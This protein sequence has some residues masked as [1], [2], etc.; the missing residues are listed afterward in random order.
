MQLTPVTSVESVTD[1]VMDFLSRLKK[2]GEAHILGVARG[3]DLSFS[4]M[5][6]L[7]VLYDCHDELA[8]HE[9]ATRLGLS[10]ATAGR[11]VQGLVRTDMVTRRED[12]HDRRVKRVRLSEH[13]RGFVNGLL[14]AHRDAVRECLESLSD[15]ERDRLSQALLPILARGD[16]PPATTTGC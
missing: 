13:G 5:R 6:A 12:T 7:F 8:V 3:L 1:Q 14:Q 9:L 16:M 10:M 15:D 11:A 4:Q 2:S